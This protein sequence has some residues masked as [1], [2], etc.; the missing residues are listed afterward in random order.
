MINRRTR[1]T[2]RA[3]LVYPNGRSPVQGEADEKKDEKTNKLQMS[4]TSTAHPYPPSG[5][6]GRVVY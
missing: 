4:S 3:C 5:G 2:K 1:N 6:R